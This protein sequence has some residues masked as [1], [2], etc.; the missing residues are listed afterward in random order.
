MKYLNS[1]I[2]SL[3]VYILEVW[4]VKIYFTIAL[5]Y[6]W[7]KEEGEGE[8]TLPQKKNKQKNV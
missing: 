7:R 4:T 8:G 3:F 6:I 2:K 5:I 1:N